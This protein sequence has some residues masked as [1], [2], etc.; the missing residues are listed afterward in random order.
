MRLSEPKR[1]SKENFMSLTSRLI[2]ILMWRYKKFQEIELKRSDSERTS[3]KP[4][5]IA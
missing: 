2:D 3:W 1:S 4:N 5:T